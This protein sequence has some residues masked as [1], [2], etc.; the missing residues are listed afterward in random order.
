MTITIFSEKSFENLSLSLKDSLESHGFE[1][2]LTS[3]ADD[4]KKQYK[5]IQ[6]SD[7]LLVLGNSIQNPALVLLN[8]AYVLNKDIFLQNLP[9][10]Q[11]E[12]KE[13]NPILF[14]NDVNKILK[15]Y[16]SLPEVYLSSQSNIK[17]KATSR[18]LRKL[19]L[20]CR[21]VGFKV[22]SDIADQPFTIEETSRGAENRLKNLKKINEGK[23][24]KFWISIE[25]GNAKL[26]ENHNVFGLNVCIVENNRGKRSLTIATDLEIPKELTD[27]V[28]SQYPDMGI[29]LQQKYGVKE[30]DP[31]TF[32]TKGKLDRG[33]LIFNSVFN[34]IASMGIHHESD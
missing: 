12:V 25:S 31:Y 27:L 26:D 14:S 3:N 24:P 5:Y 11:S 33:E 13:M 18:A 29:L 17:L 32:F 1:V 22:E 10:G 34:T 7:G 21:V 6:E 8:F 23:N 20:K 28:P 30:K 2:Y 4:I 9:E 16:E 19:G 15:Y